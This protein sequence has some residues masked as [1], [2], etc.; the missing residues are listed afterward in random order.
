MSDNNTLKGLFPKW[1]ISFEKI[2]ELFNFPDDKYEKIISV[3]MVLAVIAVFNP[4]MIAAY[5]IIHGSVLSLAFLILMVA[6]AIFSV[7]RKNFSL[8]IIGII[9]LLK[10]LLFREAM[11]DALIAC[12]IMLFI[13]LLVGFKANKSDRSLDEEHKK[14]R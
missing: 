11:S 8:I 10:L 3:C 4:I 6:L 13:Y 7:I 1:G 2:R 12:A 9:L 14:Q 5:T